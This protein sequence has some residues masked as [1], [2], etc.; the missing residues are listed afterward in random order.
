MLVLITADGR[1]KPQDELKATV[2]ERDALY[3]SMIAYGGTF[4]YSGNRI[5]HHVD[6]SWNESRNGT[7]L[8]R[9][10][11]REGDHL[12]YVT[13]PFPSQSDGGRMIVGTLVWEK[14]R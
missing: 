8:I 10:V 1:K 4:T 2:E 12:I 9:H 7:S 11:T 13:E 5:E 6:I 14:V 3:R